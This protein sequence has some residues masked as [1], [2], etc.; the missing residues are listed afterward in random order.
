[1]PAETADPRQP[2]PVHRVQSEHARARGA[3]RRTRHRGHESTWPD[4]APGPDFVEALARGLDVLRC[5]RPACPLDDAQRGRRRHRPGP[6]HRPALLSPSKSSATSARSAAAITLT[7]RVLELGM[8]YVDALGCGTS[9]GRTWRRWSRRPTSPPRWPSSTAATS[10]TSPGSRCRRSSRSASTSAP[11]SRHPRRRRAR[12]CSPLS[13]RTSWRAVLAEPSR[14]G[15][16]PTWQPAPG[17]L[18][19]ELRE[20]RARGWALAD[21]ELAPGV[22]SVADRRTRRRRRRVVAAMNVTVH[23]AE[24]SLEH[25]ARG[26]PAQAAARRRRHQ[27]RLGAD[28]RRAG[29]HR[30]GALACRS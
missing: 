24:T 16:P 15:M 12:C 20:V 23:A 2:V 5:F 26:A 28:R 14:S 13:H 7:P 3:D 18:D 25:A 27:A 29:G 17:D 30:L 8:A 10:S 1:M 19:A 4:G 21:E 9:P 22:R 6:P 11:A